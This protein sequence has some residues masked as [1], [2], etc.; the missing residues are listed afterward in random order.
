[1]SGGN[2]VR[3]KSLFLDRP[4]VTRRLDRGTV[5]AFRIVGG[6]VRLTARNS[7]RNAPKK[8]RRKA[9]R[10]APY[11]RTGRLKKSIFFSVDAE[12]DS[13]LVGP[14]K[15]DGKKTGKEE[16]PELLEFGGIGRNT[17]TGEPA[18]YEGFPYMT[19]AFE[20]ELPRVDDV[21]RDVVK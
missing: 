9:G 3:I 13:L 10:R 6:R 18:V 17:R 5:K 12:A 2:F 4:E 15:L 21:F 20:R 19:P 7:I 16:V 1:M 14:I 8:A 11:N